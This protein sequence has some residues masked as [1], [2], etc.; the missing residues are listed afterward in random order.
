VK[1]PTKNA[2]ITGASSGIGLAIASRLLQSGNISIVGL[3]RRPGPLA[4]QS[5][6]RHWPTDLTD[7]EQTAARARRY[8]QEVKGCHLLV[9][10]AGMAGFAPTD[11]WEPDKLAALVTLNLT[12]P[13][14]LCSEM[15]AGLRQTESSLVV[16]VG[17]TSS[18][19]RAPLGA[20]YAATKGGLHRF[21]ESLFVESR[22]QAIRV[23]HLCPGPTD[24][25]FYDQQRFRPKAGDETVLSCDDLAAV[26]EFF[27]LGPGRRMNPTHLVLEPQRVEFEKLRKRD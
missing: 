25:A 10:A 23:L 15:L 6:Y 27:L 13:M 19:E 24:T 26:V 21:A 9:C 22:K 4:G 8:R 7:L 16:L 5:G 17:S 18:R 14:L 12:S 2:L 1:E 20:A 11:A 3:S